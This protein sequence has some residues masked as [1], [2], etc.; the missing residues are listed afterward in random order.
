LDP[1]ITP[2]A[3]LFQATRVALARG[4]DVQEVKRLV[5][6]HSQGRAFGFL[7]EPRVNVLKLN[8]ALQSMQRPE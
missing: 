8:I 7:G 5:L 2:A 3:A 4:L 6:E 1:E